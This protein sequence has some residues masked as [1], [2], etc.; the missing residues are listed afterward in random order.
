M[1]LSPKYQLIQKLAREFAEN[2]IPES[3]QEEIDQT[4]EFPKSLYNKITENGF[5]GLK[6]PKEYGGQGG[7]QSV[8]CSV[9]RADFPRQHGH[10]HLPQRSKLSRQRPHCSTRGTPEQLEK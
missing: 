6:V 3:M 9:R 2:E 5:F 8:L 1:I 7:G 4:G 10:L